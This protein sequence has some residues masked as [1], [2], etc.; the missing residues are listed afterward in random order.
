MTQ[1]TAIPELSRIAAASLL[2]AS[3]ALG[4]SSA[5]CR[6]SSGPTVTIETDGGGVSIRVRLAATPATRQRGLMFE[7]NLPEGTGM[8]FLF[9]N[10]QQRSFWMKNTPLPLDIIYIGADRRIV[11]IA[12]STMPYSEKTIASDGPSMYVLEVPGGYCAKKDIK[13]GQHIQLPYPLPASS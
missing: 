2:A 5:A 12:E 7:S 10:E 3:L 4:L 8:L 13:T 9:P 1:D 6:G 11:S